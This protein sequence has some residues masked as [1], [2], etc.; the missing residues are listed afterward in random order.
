MQLRTHI[1][2]RFKNYNTGSSG[3]DARSQPINTIILQPFIQVTFLNEC[4]SGHGESAH[5]AN[6]LLNSISQSEFLVAI[7]ILHV[8]LGI[9]FPLSKLLQQVNN[10]LVK[11]TADIKAVIVAVEQLRSN[12]NIS[13]PWAL[14]VKLAERVDVDIRKP[15]AVGNAPK[16]RILHV[17]FV[18]FSGGHTPG[19]PRREE[20]PVLPHPPAA[21]LN[22]A[23]GRRAPPA[24]QT[25]TPTHTSTPPKFK[26]LYNTLVCKHLISLD[27]HEGDI[28][29][30]TF[31]FI[32]K[33]NVQFHTSW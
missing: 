20:R 13:F 4:G 17:K 26:I 1:R 8:V 11:A 23:R 18:N 3:N 2:V 22:H 33:I 15:R 10:D 19:P 31:K 27:R 28:H 25:Q 7:A 6:M 16:F 14:A 5:K 30:R 24:P 29:S 21:W 32:G 12:A 9:T